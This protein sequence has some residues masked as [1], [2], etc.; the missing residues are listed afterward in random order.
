MIENKLQETVA[1]YLK[2]QFSWD[3]VPND[4]VIQQTRN[5][6]EGELTVVL[7]PFLKIAKTSPEELGKKVGNYLID[8]VE[9]IDDFNTV[10][11]FLNLQLTA[12][13]WVDLSLQAATDEE[14]GQFAP[15]DE[16]IVV[17][18]SS[19]NTN[20]PLHLGHIRNI[21]LGSSIS[22]ILEANGHEV[23]R[24]Q[25]VNDRGIA[26]CKSIVAW[27]KFG[28]GATPEKVD[29]K[30][31]KF[32]GDYYVLFEKE[33]Q[34]EYKN[35]QQTDM[36]KDT[37]KQKSREG[38]SEEEFYKRFKNQYFNLYSILGKEAKDLLLMWEKDDPDTVSLWETMNNWVYDGF[39]VTYESLGV[40]FDKNYY[41]SDTYQIGKKHVLHGLDREIFFKKEDG[42]IWVD[43]T[44]R[45][46][47]E[48]ILLRADGTSLYITQDIGTAEERFR[49]HEMDR[50]IYVVGNEQE[51][52]FKVLFEVLDL[53]GAR[54]ADQ[55][56]HL[57]YGMVDLPTGKM[58]SR[59]GTVV[60]ADDLIEEVIREAESNAEERGELSELSQ[61]ERNEVN[62]KI[63]LAA[64]KF[65]IIKVQP[66]KGM[67]FDP[68]ESVDLQGQTGPY[69]Q[70]AFVRIQSIFRKV[71]EPDYSTL[72]TSYDLKEQERE[73]S[74]ALL[75]FPEVIA[76]AGTEYDPS[77]VANYAY[78][79]A[80]L[81]HRF[82]HDISI[83]REQD[84]A[85]QNF[86]LIL[87]EAVANVLKKAMN[88][89]GIEMPQ[90]M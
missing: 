45:G 69:I 7:F 12:D 8:K 15:T 20:K 59:E 26:I 62:R 29:K 80:R 65:F 61:D 50:M 16:K 49:D 17:E 67:L 58:K 40:E 78:E 28:E 54:Y 84:Q 14:F 34:K 86:R 77:K 60:D 51:Y 81:F 39:K 42:S 22:N 43:L 82:Y 13:F 90:R 31:D 24:T 4:V 18:F 37:F 5:E 57:S 75:Q 30:G 48:K 79:L 27:Q 55:C 88:L 41:E 2:D 70:N 46:L 38:E 35:W 10:K 21:L 9:E 72:P 44:D 33:F 3:G 85:V 74:A 52:H 76:S 32:V 64:L 19:P 23:I 47:D 11:G 68:K 1:N 66:S 89:L 53:L 73:L 6:Y 83:M 63:G 71:G 87:A 25:V 56:Y 36:G